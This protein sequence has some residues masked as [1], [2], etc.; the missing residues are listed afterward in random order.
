MH[1]A[2]SGAF[3]CLHQRTLPLDTVCVAAWSPVA[4]LLALVFA[5]ASVV[6]LRL[7]WEL[8]G[9]WRPSEASAGDSIPKVTCL[10]WSPHEPRLLLGQS[11]GTLT[12]LSV[13]HMQ[14]MT[15][16]EADDEPFDVQYGGWKRLVW[17]PLTDRKESSLAL[18]VR[19]HGADIFIFIEGLYACGMFDL[20]RLGSVEDFTTSEDTRYLAALGAGN[21]LLIGALD[22]VR[23]RFHEWGR[24]AH[25]SVQTRERIFQ[26]QLATQGIQEHWQATA[27][28]MYQVLDTLTETLVRYR[29]EAD[30][31][32]AFRELLLLAYGMAPAPAVRDWLANTMS[33]S[34]QRSCSRTVVTSLR[35]CVEIARTQ[36]LPLLNALLA[37]VAGLPDAGPAF[38]A[39]TKACWRLGHGIALMLQRVR[40]LYV[41]FWSWLAGRSDENL[42]LVVDREKIEALFRE[43]FFGVADM[44]AQLES[45]TRALMTLE[46]RLNDLARHHQSRR[47]PLKTA[48]SASIPQSTGEPSSLQP[49]LQRQRLR[50]MVRWL[51]SMASFQVCTESGDLWLI[52]TQGTVALSFSIR[53][54]IQSSSETSFVRVAWYRDPKICVLTSAGLWCLTSVKTGDASPPRATESQD[55]FRALELTAPA[56]STSSFG[57]A[58]PEVLQIPALVCGITRGLACIFASASRVL[59]FDLEDS[60]VDADAATEALP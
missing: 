52:S 1:T 10:C 35:A 15:I 54:L 12:L 2:T 24:F 16:Y 46:T 5:P 19:E 17:I 48:V 11:D 41:M 38:T 51:P 42:R 18:G 33:E 23:P 32:T 57:S 36:L 56:S 20:A 27:R 59:V 55:L 7:N 34:N 13:E 21:T 47:W 26:L 29:P 4:D 30:R 53:Y 9:V 37:Q 22:E 50:P 49:L 58:F 43:R 39:E 44:D 6:I 25:W 31:A 60:D 45:F 14:C 3:A 28:V 40:P 8:V